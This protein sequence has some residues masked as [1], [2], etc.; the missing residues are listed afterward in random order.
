[1]TNNCGWSWTISRNDCF[2]GCWIR[3]TP[4]R[5]QWEWS[6]FST[7]SNSNTHQGSPRCMENQWHFPPLKWGALDWALRVLNEDFLPEPSCKTPATYPKRVGGREGTRRGGIELHKDRL[8]SIISL[9]LQKLEW[10]NVL[11]WLSNTAYG[12]DNFLSLS[13][14]TFP[15]ILPMDSVRAPQAGIASLGTFWV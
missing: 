11:T 10:R 12:P 2:L 9:P 1:M 3:K 8:I 6:L 4:H 7:L 13:P 5:K 14:S 15:K